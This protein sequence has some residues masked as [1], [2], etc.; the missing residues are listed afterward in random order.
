[1]SFSNRLVWF[2]TSKV[3]IFS[4]LT[5][6][7]VATAGAEMAATEVDVEAAAA[8]A[9]AVEADVEDTETAGE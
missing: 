6:D 4:L 7:T 2:L 3:L 8:M 9:E 5:Q 1:M